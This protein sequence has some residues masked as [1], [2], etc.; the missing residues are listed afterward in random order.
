MDTM[1]QNFHSLNKNTDFSPFLFNEGSVEGASNF[2]PSWPH[3]F[4]WSQT[5][6][7]VS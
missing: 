3:L 1:K 7:V 2:I 4:K 5:T 6:S